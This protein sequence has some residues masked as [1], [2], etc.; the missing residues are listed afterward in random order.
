MASVRPSIQPGQ[1]PLFFWQNMPSHH[2]TGALEEL[3]AIW[4]GEVTAVW[5]AGLSDERIS[6]GWQNPIGGKLRQIC[7]PDQGWE[8]MAD[9]IVDASP[10][11]VHIFSGIGAY[12][13]LDRAIGRLKANKCPGIG[14]IAE[15]VF[16]EPHLHLPRYLKTRFSYAPY[17]RMIRAA[18]GIG[19]S[20]ERFFKMMGLREEV[21]FPYLYQNAGSAEPRSEGAGRLAF[22][23]KLER[24]KGVD[25]LLAALAGCRDLA[26]TLDVYGDG[27]MRGTLAALASS[28]GLAERVAFHGVIPSDQVVRRLC[29]ADI[30]IVPSRYDG[31]GMATSEA[32]HA[33]ATVIV[34]DAA[35]SSDIPSACGVGACFRSGDVAGLREELRL[36]LADPAVVA[37]E[38]AAARSLAEKIAPAAVARFLDAALRHA[39]LQEGLRPKAPWRC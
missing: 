33:G 14:I 15:T 12:P 6:D 38:Q 29:H 37:R 10:H 2:Q 5:S 1:P 25:I 4:P 34:S 36:R 19:L 13:R 17:L 28:S 35:G 3:A 27:A 11:G 39:F 16:K 26:W 18:F 22:V 21:I 31:W 30:C 32:V 7:L 8:A 23:G 20:G 9:A 24:Y